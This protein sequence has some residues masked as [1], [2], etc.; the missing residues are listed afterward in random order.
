MQA[1]NG[2]VLVRNGSH[3]FGKLIQGKAPNVR[4]AEEIHCPAGSV[5]LMRPLLSHSSIASVAKSVEHRRTVHLE[6]SP[7]MELP[8]G[9]RWH[10]FNPL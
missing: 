7:M 3:L 6:L 4:D 2:P 5:M 1:N 9:Y 10:T 8:F